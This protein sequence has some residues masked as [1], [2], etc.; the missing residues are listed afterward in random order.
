MQLKIVHTSGRCRKMRNVSS[1]KFFDTKI[2][3][4]FKSSV[5][6]NAKISAN[7]SSGKEMWTMAFLVFAAG[8][9]VST[10]VGKNRAIK[11]VH[12]NLKY[13]QNWQKYFIFH[14]RWMKLIKKNR[15]IQ[16]WPK[17]ALPVGWRNR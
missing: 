17:V 11:F 12:K 14:R 6:V 16:W 9:D 13:L 10:N 1:A 5:S 4:C 3:R 8:A 15:Y 7:V 2:N